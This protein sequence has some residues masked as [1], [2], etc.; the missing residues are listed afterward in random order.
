MTLYKCGNYFSPSAFAGR[1][2]ISHYNTIRVSLS[3][4]L[5]THGACVC[6]CV[7]NKSTDNNFQSLILH[8]KWELGA[9]EIG[10]SDDNHENDVIASAMI[11]YFSLLHDARGE[12]SGRQKIARSA[13]FTE[14]MSEWWKMH[15]MQ[16]QCILSPEKMSSLAHISPS[17]PCVCVPVCLVVIQLFAAPMEISLV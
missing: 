10:T 2:M 9:R 3:S 12:H 13:M 7:C 17:L 8:E 5:S 14:Y 4:F 6:V 16:R 1:L 11:L 15:T